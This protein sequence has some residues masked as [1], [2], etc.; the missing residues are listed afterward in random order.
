[1]KRNGSNAEVRNTKTP[2]PC[3]GQK[4]REEEKKKRRG[5]V[6]GGGENL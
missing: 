2:L 1:M 3:G 6:E 5:A 4:E